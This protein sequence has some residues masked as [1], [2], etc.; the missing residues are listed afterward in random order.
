LLLLL[1][2]GGPARD[3]GLGFFVV[4]VGRRRRRW[5]GRRGRRRRWRGRRRGCRIVRAV[6]VGRRWQWRRWRRSGGGSGGGLLMCLAAAASSVVVIV[7][8]R[9]RWWWWWTCR[10]VHWRRRRW[11]GGRVGSHWGG[12]VGSQVALFFC[13]AC[14][15][16]GGPL[17][18]ARVLFQRAIRVAS[19]GLDCGSGGA[20]LREKKR[21]SLLL[22]FLHQLSLPVPRRPHTTLYSRASRS[23]TPV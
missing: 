6:G 19:W 21:R 9:R 20:R 1:L 14:L 10:L 11:R 13:H 16:G 7:G 2:L 5:R 15:G 18:R 12:R 23:S 4:A 3:D 22:P 8:W 17:S